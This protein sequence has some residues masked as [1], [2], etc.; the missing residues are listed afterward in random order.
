MSKVLSVKLDEEKMETIEEIARDEG[1][2]K[3]AV[4]RKLLD[5]G[6]K[7][8]RIDKAIR[9]IVEGR[10]SVWKASEIA[11]VSLR[12]ML[13]ILDEKKITWIKITPQ[14]FEREMEKIKGV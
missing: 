3:S 5:A 6:I 8:W 9:L 14:D 11:G 4:A 7:R 13:K 10:V 12:E 2:G 1:L